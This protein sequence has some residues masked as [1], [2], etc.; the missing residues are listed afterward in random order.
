VGELL[1][2]QQKKPVLEMIVPHK[3]GDKKMKG[4]SPLM[5]VVLLVA[6]TLAVA[7]VI[8]GWL[9][10]VS[11]QETEIA[12][13]ALLTQVNCSK[14]VLSIIDVTCTDTDLTIAIANLGPIELTNPSFYARLSNGTSSTWSTT[15]TI[16]S[17]GQLL[18]TTSPNWD[19][20]TLDYVSVT[21]LCGGASGISAERTGI[22]DAC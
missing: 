17:G 10:S 20:G 22:G 12:G 3:K 5:A 18:D 21:A 2:Y 16:S 14:A 15:A 19:G 4:I 13:E 6:F 8:G 11:R 7:V 9:T 1:P